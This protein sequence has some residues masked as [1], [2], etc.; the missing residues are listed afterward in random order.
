MLYNLKPQCC[1]VSFKF[2]SFIFLPL[3]SS[4]LLSYFSFLKQK[5]EHPLPHSFT[6]YFFKSLPF[7]LHCY[8]SLS[9]PHL[10]LSQWSAAVSDKCNSLSY[11]REWGSQII[12][13]IKTLSWYFSLSIKFSSVVQLCLTLWDPMN[14]TTPGL[15]VHYQLLEFTQTLVHQV[16]DAIQPSHPLSSPS[17]TVP[18]CSQHQGLFQRVNSSHQVA[19]VLEIQVQHQSFQWTPRTGLL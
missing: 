14:H 15:H 11:F 5:D 2:P 10:C 19:T 7:P 13:A 4:L 8:L 17:P 1:E 16:G 18:N 9:Y 3:Y 6:R 12:K